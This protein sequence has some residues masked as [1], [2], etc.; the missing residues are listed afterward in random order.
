M[1]NPIQEFI[2]V[3]HDNNYVPKYRDIPEDFEHYD[4]LKAEIHETGE[5]PES[6]RYFEINGISRQYDM[7][8]YLASIFMTFKSSFIDKGYLKDNVNKK[9]I[10]QQFNNI[11][12]ELAI[13][14]KQ[15]RSIGDID[16][17]AIIDTKIDYCDKAIE[18]IGAD[19]IDDSK[20]VYYFT[21]EDEP[22][23]KFHDILDEIHKGLQDLGYIDCSKPTFKKLF[24]KFNDKKPASSPTPIIWKGKEYKHLSYFIYLLSN[25]LLT[26]QNVP[27]NYKIALN[28]FYKMKEGEYFNPPEKNMKYCGVIKKSKAE[29]EI[30][31][32]SNFLVRSKK[33]D[34]K[35]E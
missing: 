9:A 4:E 1:T 34:K 30:A 6:M 21:F 28:L 11:R 18:F 29:K 17:N 13:I 20:P 10:K 7:E 24:I 26:R 16:L 12:E 22:S 14:N 31:K 33:S 3:L 23:D 8:E 35:D 5:L 15:V 19:T 2:K 25:S 27:S 32:I